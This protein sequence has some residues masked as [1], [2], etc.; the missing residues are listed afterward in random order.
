MFSNKE[1]FIY[2]IIYHIVTIKD[3]EKNILFFKKNLQMKVIDFTKIVEII[4]KYLKL[5]K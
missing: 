2:A 4:N 5:K 1:N 3:I